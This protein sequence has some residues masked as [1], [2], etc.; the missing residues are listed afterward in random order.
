ME[1]EVFTVVMIRT[2]KSGATYEAT[3]TGTAKAVLLSLDDS[4]NWGDVICEFDVHEGDVRWLR[5]VTGKQ[6]G[7][8]HV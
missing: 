7:R 4:L 3:I 6:I 5:I 1:E 8:A 2:S